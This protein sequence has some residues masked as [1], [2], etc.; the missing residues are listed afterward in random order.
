MASLSVLLLFW[1][2]SLLLLLHM[3]QL[4]T[5]CAHFVRFTHIFHF[6]FL[7]AAL[8]SAIAFPSC[9]RRCP[10]AIARLAF[11]PI[12]LLPCTPLRPPALSPFSSFVS[13]HLVFFC[14]QKVCEAALCVA[15]VVATAAAASV[16][17]CCGC[18]KNLYTALKQ[19]N[20]MAQK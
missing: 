9:R 20:E 17:C 8:S 6:G 13:F 5:G 7:R 4:A 14:T 3:P 18:L 1:V 15:A 19:H 12:T 16:C 11:A 2:R 10:P